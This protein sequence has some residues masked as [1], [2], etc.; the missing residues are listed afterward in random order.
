MKHYAVVLL[1]LLLAA[2]F[3]SPMAM[4]QDTFRLTVLGYQWTTTHNTMTFTWPGHSNTSC[5]GN[6][7]MNGNISNNGDIYANGTS[8]S[9][10]STTFTPPS[11]QNIDIRK[12][13]V[14]ILAESDTSRMVMTCTRNVRWS[15]CHA[16]NP[17]AFLGRIEK[18]HLEVQA[19]LGKKDE[20]I[21][22]DVVQQTAIS[23]QSSNAATPAS[24]GDGT[25]SAARVVEML[26]SRFVADKVVGYAESAGDTL[27][28]HSEPASGMRFHM[29]LAD[30]RELETLRAAGF[31]TV[32][33]TNDADVNLKGDVESGRIETQRASK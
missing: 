25:M 11:S 26:N 1:P 30:K 12:P 5:N 27:T 33:Y 7:Y 13:V 20:W 2:C 19:T 21:K 15:Q 3:L 32:L 24:P 9:T 23:G 16:L 17:G 14:Y 28:I 8:S 31:K 10:C 29:M 6:T 4:A 18:G 22:F